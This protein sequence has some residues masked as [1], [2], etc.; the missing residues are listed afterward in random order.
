MIG[1]KTPTAREVAVTAPYMHDDSIATLEDVIEFYD[2]G[3]NPNPYLD[4]ELR[5]LRLTAEEKEALLSFLK[6]LSGEISGDC[7]L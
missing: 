5:R 3:G 1:G 2:W 4:P 7:S 6:S